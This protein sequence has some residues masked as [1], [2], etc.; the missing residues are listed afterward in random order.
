[1]NRVILYH[2][3]LPDRL[4]PADTAALLERIPYA[5]RVALAARR[6]DREASLAGIALAL[7][8]A[9]AV[10]G[11]PL[12]PE[13]LRF[14]PDGKP[15]F[16]SHDAPVF[17]ISHSARTVVACA[18]AVGAVGV[19]IEN[20]AGSALTAAL[21]REWT[22]REAVVKAAG[23]GLRA[24]PD[25]SLRGASAHLRGCDYHLHPLQLPE[26]S[27]GF[28]ALAVA[29]SHVEIVERDPLEALRRHAA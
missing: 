8:A 20:D 25:V 24:A 27:A 14:P 19:D 5:K 9:A 4:V 3:R 21:R 23:A 10:R 16:A 1:M 29:P 12:A 18:A 6:A 7:A 15:T 28:I 2:A 11:R 26:G 22:A 13:S 17:S